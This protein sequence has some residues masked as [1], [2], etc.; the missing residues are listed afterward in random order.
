MI[1]VVAGAVDALG[2][3][4][5]L[6]DPETAKKSIKASITGPKRIDFEVTVQ[7]SGNTNVKS[8]TLKF[9]FYFGAAA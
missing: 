4:A 9:G 6:S 1:A 8:A 7:L 3:A 2:K 5:I